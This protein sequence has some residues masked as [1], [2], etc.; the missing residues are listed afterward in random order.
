MNFKDNKK[1]KVKQIFDAI[2]DSSDVFLVVANGQ[3]TMSF[4]CSDGMGSCVLNLMVDT[5][6]TEM[7]KDARE[8]VQSITQVDRTTDS[9]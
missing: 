2:D 3:H 5:L 8:P 7:I 9:T 4:V 6:K 1:D